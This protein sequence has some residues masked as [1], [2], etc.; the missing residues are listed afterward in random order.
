MDRMRGRDDD[1]RNLPW[2]DDEC[3][4]NLRGGSTQH[5]NNGWREE[6][7]GNIPIG[8]YGKPRAP[9]GGENFTN[10]GTGGSPNPRFGYKRGQMKGRDKLSRRRW[11]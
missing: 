10:L 7:G 1:N 6:Q 8:G 11:I 5:F 9:C 4:S 3:A 2:H